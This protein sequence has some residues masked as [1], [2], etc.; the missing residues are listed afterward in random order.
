VAQ[1]ANARLVDELVERFPALRPAYEDHL[2]DNAELLPHLFFW[3][4]TQ[5]AER[6]YTSGETATLQRC[7][8]SSKALGSTG[9]RK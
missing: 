6:L 4:V 9:R 3:D 8:T 2:R 5:Y 7:S 1:E